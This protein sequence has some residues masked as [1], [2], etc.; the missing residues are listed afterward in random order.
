MSGALWRSPQDGAVVISSKGSRSG[1]FSSFFLN[2]SAQLSSIEIGS[3]RQ[4]KEK[5]K[6]IIIMFASITQSG[7]ET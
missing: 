6:P 7:N 2:P 5:K 3:R 1:D 4:V